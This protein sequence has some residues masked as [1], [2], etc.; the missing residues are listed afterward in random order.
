MGKYTE[1]IDESLPSVPL[2]SEED[3]QKA[4]LT[5]CHHVQTKGYEDQKETAWEFL[6]MLGLLPGEELRSTSKANRKKN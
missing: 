2:V 3:E 5:V 1:P 4:R 6:S